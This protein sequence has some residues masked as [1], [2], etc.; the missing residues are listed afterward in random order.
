[1]DT[2]DQNAAASSAAGESS[3]P[4]GQFST[5]DRGFSYMWVMGLVSAGMA[6]VDWIS[7]AFLPITLRHFTDSPFYIAF[8]LSLNRLFGFVVQ[9]YVAWK[10]DHIQT[11]FGRRRPFFF[12]GNPMTLLSLIGL[13][14]MPYVFTGDARKSAIAVACL[15]VLNF[16]LQFFMDFT[17][18]C[19]DP[20][21]ADT[22]EQKKLGRAASIR[23]YCA[24]FLTLSMSLIALRLADIHEIFP[25]VFASGYVLLSLTLMVFVV[26]EKPHARVIAKD[27]YS[28][29][30][31][32]RML[33]NPEYGRLA[34]I[35]AMALCLPA[36][37]SLFNSLFITQT[38]GLTKTQMGLA[39][40]FA[41][42]VHFV[43]AFPL[44]YLADRF[45][46]RYLLG[47]GFFG[48][49]CVNTAM[50]FL[51]HDFNTLVI[52]TLINSG[53]MIFSHVPMTSMIFQYAS[54]KE[55]GTIFGLIQFT[56]GAAAFVITL[57]LGWAV[58]Q[59]RSYDPTPIY[60]LDIKNPAALQQRILNP[61]TPFEQYLNENFKDETLKELSSA[62]D[63]D[64]MKKPLAAGLN[65][66]MNGKNIY[67]EK[68]FEGV[69]LSRQSRRLIDRAD[70]E[71]RLK[72]FNR[73]LIQDA[74]PEDLSA[75]ANF[76]I[77]YIINI[78]IALLASFLA[79]TS[80]EGKYS[81]KIDNK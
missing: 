65:D 64:A 21:Y 70:S 55:R 52:V 48:I 6:S 35:A 37:T 47:A 15:I 74:F 78:L 5:K 13:G 80:R 45:G 61:Q 31:H 24:T 67:E 38:L 8:L 32:F 42:L 62:P 49:A 58:Q 25:F 41:P 53:I 12:V 60:T 22:F 57:L 16:M 73:S 18:G 46:P 4:S 23:T 59:S 27:R 26:R 11:R 30:K 2:K 33:R 63:K 36:S 69:E 66:I 76:R 56:R 77:S 68:R 7:N 1:M 50:A 54:P 19:L 40:G 75:K 10:S 14:L 20:L 34:A 81:Q 39:V 3:V 79:F 29:L 44:G 17:M 51:V 72:V 71:K 9:P 28:I 43:V